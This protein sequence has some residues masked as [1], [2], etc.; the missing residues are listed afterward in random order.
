MI[1]FVSLGIAVSLF[2]TAAALAACN[3]GSGLYISG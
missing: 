2:V 1:R 3:A